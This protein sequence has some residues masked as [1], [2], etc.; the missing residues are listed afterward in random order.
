MNLNNTVA[1][2]GDTRLTLA[3]FLHWLKARGQLVPLVRAAL[4][5]RVVQEMA[6]RADLSVTSEELQAAANAWRRRQGLS[7]VLDTHNWLAER[8][9]SVD[10]FEAGLE[11]LLLLTKLRRQVPASAVEARFAAEHAGYERLRLAELCLGREDLAQELAS[12]VRE[13]GR[14]LDTV[15][16]EQRLQVV[17]GDCYRKDVTGPLAEALASTAVGQLVG[18]V[19]T[20]RGFV[21]VLLEECQPAV[22][23]PITRLHIANEIFESKWA[24]LLQG[25]TLSLEPAETS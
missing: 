19:A 13:E 23:D 1:A 3:D 2:L 10:E 24:T 16:G 17:R 8:G 6:Q 21:L 20:P 22:L 7:A 9:M 18:P 4:A 12:Q 14:N 11:S 15:A 5:D 25:A